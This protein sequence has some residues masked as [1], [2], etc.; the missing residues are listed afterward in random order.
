MQEN[1]VYLMIV[2]KPMD[3]PVTPGTVYPEQAPTA[4]PS[5]GNPYYSNQGYSAPLP[6][7]TASNNPFYANRSRAPEREDARDRKEA[8]Q[9]DE[10]YDDGD[11][12]YDRKR[13]Y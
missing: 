4:G 2:N 11:Y 6:R 1:L 13:K 9:E 12:E 8:Q 3:G 7:E 10:Y 5:S